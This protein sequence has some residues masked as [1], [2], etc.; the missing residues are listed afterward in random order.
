M[1]KAAGKPRLEAISS[2]RTRVLA[3]ACCEADGGASVWLAN[4]RDTPQR[5][6]LQGLDGDTLRV[7][8]LD[9]LTFEAAA[10]DPNF[11]AAQ[12]STQRTRE[13]EIGAYGVVYVQVGA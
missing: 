12:A 2:D 4:L 9:E 11:L 1:A 3:V 7:G 8:R 5:V 6:T 13:V 10:A